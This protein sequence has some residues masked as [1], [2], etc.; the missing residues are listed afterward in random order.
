M[1]FAH[2][3][4]LPVFILVASPAL[5]FEL[6]HR[7]PEQRRLRI[8]LEPQPTQVQQDFDKYVQE[9]AAAARRDADSPLA[10]KDAVKELQ[11]KALN[12]AVLFR[13]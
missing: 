7:A 3:V 2:L 8:E 1:K 13:W 11:A 10:K 12:P 9:L 6:Q 5:G 4:F